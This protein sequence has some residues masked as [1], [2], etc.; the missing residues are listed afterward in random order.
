[1]HLVNKKF[2]QMKWKFSFVKDILE[3]EQTDKQLLKKQKVGLKVQ[4]RPWWRDRSK[5]NTLQMF[6]DGNQ[7]ETMQL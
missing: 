2:Y 7:L 4:S 5:E 1:M 3:W 6:M